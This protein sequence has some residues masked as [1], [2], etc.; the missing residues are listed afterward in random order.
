MQRF[1]I[2]FCNLTEMKHQKPVS[3]LRLTQHD[4]QYFLMSRN[5][6]HSNI[7]FADYYHRKHW[8]DR[9]D[10][11]LSS[12]CLTFPLNTSSTIDLGNL[13]EFKPPSIAPNGNVGTPSK[14]FLQAI[15][16]CRL[17]S[18]SIKKL[19]INLAERRERIFSSVAPPTHVNDGTSDRNP[20]RN[21]RVLPTTL[22]FQKLKPQPLRQGQFEKHTLGIGRRVLETSGWKDG[23]GL[24]KSEQGKPDV[25]DFRGQ[26]G[27]SGL[28]CK[29]KPTNITDGSSERIPERNS[30]QFVLPTSLPTGSATALTSKKA[31]A[32]S[33]EAANGAVDPTNVTDGSSERNPER[34]LQILPTF[35][36]TTD[37][38]R[39]DREYVYVGSAT[40][41]TSQKATAVSNEAANG[42]VGGISPK[43]PKL[44]KND[45]T[46]QKES[47]RK[48]RRRRG[49]GGGDGSESPT[50]DVVN[51]ADDVDDDLDYD[52][53]E[54]DRH[55]G[56]HNDV[57]ARRVVDNIEDMN[58]QPGTYFCL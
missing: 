33:N 8:T 2:F 17:S 44:S 34:N 39:K 57:S 12:I 29:E 16:E 53:E 46:N 24:G 5:S 43:R 49:G 50:I 20:E 15:S 3:T 42:A 56:L 19:G 32:V 25:A 41:L 38:S 10:E 11:E 14:Y 45:A 9:E 40:L 21:S 37:S 30:V 4:L 51:N 36:P 52:E 22:P 35:L 31:A 27:R 58:D 28:G 13:S 26:Q 54:W 55:R 48:R 6:N 7:F 18:K 1:D 23:H 47:Q